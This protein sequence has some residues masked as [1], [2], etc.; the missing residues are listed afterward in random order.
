MK[1]AASPVGCL[2]GHSSFGYGGGAVVELL[3]DL[4]EL[5]LLSLELVAVDVYNQVVESFHLGFHLPSFT[6]RCLV[7]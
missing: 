1:R 7:V 4:V 6:G 5:V 2:Y 3:V